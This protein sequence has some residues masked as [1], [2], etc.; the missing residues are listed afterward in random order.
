MGSPCYLHIANR[1]YRL[2]PAVPLEIKA[3]IDTI[4]AIMLAHG[5]TI[6][7]PKM[8]YSSPLLL[9]NRGVNYEK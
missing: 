4:A 1:H 9:R 5:H 7:C 8:R 2:K 6:L 3:Q